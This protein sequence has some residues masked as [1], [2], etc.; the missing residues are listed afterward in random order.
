MKSVYVDGKIMQ[1]MGHFLPTI[2]ISHNI[3]KL[4]FYWNKHVIEIHVL[5]KKTH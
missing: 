5:M 1:M 4:Q 3:P 2:H